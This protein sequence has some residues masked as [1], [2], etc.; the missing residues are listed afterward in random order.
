MSPSL[1]TVIP[2]R[3]LPTPR[4]HY[5]PVV[6]GAGCVF[7]SGLVGLDPASGR[8]VDGDHAQARQ[9][10]ANLFALCAE[11]G[12]SP[13][14][15]LHARVYCAAQASAAEVNRAWDEA[16]TDV[17]PPARTFVTV[18]ALP[19]GAAVEIDFVLADGQAT[20]LP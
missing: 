11:H 2:S 3:S 4:F 12:W 7:V 5:S 13:E 16:F 14:Q 8:L 15:I 20:P 18:H 19:I 17:V 1:R 9:V 6:R 10:L